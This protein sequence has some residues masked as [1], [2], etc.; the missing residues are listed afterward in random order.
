MDIVDLI[1]LREHLARRRIEGTN[2]S[3][4]QKQSLCGDQRD[5]RQIKIQAARVRERDEEKVRKKIL[6]IAERQ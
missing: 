1:F 2:K 3:R 6:P 4:A 5:H